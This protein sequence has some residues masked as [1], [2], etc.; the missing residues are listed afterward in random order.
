MKTFKLFLYLMTM[1]CVSIACSS[2][3]EDSDLTSNAPVNNFEEYLA[4]GNIHNDMLD[5]A[6]SVCARLDSRSGEFDFLGDDAELFELIHQEQIEAVRNSSMDERDKNSL[7]NSLNEYIGFYQTENVY[8]QLIS[9]DSIPSTLKE[10]ERNGIIDSFEFDLLIELYNITI[11]NY[12]T[13]D[14]E[15]MSKMINSL[16][17]RWE[18]YYGGMDKKAGVLSGYILGISKSSINW[19]NENYT[20]T[21]VVPFWVATDVA[22]ALIS[23]VI[24]AGLQWGSSGK[25]EWKHVGFAALGGAITSS[26][27]V[28]RV[29][30]PWIDKLLNSI[31]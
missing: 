14:Q 26:T 31:F 21:R 20:P 10:L 11:D 9:T 18:N 27:G 5:V 15:E 17:V 23:G 29:T 7:I 2:S 24:H 1:L 4:F 6:C 16:C 13:G 3:H 28:V 22:G 30:G 12:N 25:V 19:W 8:N